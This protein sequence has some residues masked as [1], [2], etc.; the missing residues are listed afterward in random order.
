MSLGA[1]L[2]AADTASSEEIQLKFDSAGRFKIVQFTDLHLH[3]GGEKDRQTLALI[4]QILDVE[5]PQ[6]VVLTGDTLSGAA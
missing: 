4:G 1:A 5:K 6:L 2:S 3:E